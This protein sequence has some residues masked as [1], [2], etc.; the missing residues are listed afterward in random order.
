MLVSI[1]IA[2]YNAEPYI[3]EAVESAL[4]QSYKNIEVI[5]CD[6]ASTDNTFNVL[7][8]ID[9]SR[10]KIIRNENNLGYLKTFNRLISC[11]NGDFI[12]FVDADDWIDLSK[13]EK[14]VGFLLENPEIGLVG[15]ACART[16]EFGNVFDQERYPE[17]HEV[18]EAYVNKESKIL[19]CGSSVMLRKCVLE[20][21][22]GYKEFFIGMPSEDCDWI[23]RIMDEYK[24]ANLSDVLY[25]YRFSKG[26]LTRVVH[27]SV[28]KRHSK[29]IALFLRKQRLANVSRL[30]SLTGLSYDK[31][32][33]FILSLENKYAVNPGSLFFSTT[34]EHAINGSV[35][36][37][38]VDFYRFSSIRN[39]SILRKLKLLF[40]IT[41]ILIFPNSLL[42]KVKKAI[43]LKNVSNSF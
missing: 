22:G 26:S 25:Y 10:L 24:V 21:V 7:A 40:L 29:E 23:L 6:D 16:D 12:S 37:S 2:A 30:D 5:I 33:S 8:V 19:F 35:R 18:L 39:V 28:T 14:Q 43:G 15:T 41:I 27:Y 13:V 38:L 20:K 17:N 34:I 9:D 1:C 32:E 36:K 3:L 11:A 31:L 42:L 4:N